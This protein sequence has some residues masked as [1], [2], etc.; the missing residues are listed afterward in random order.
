VQKRSERNSPTKRGRGG[1]KGIVRNT[2]GTREAREEK[3]AG[4]VRQ[5]NT[6]KKATTLEIRSIRS[7]V[8]T[9]R[10]VSYREHGMRKV[11]C[12]REGRVAILILSGKGRIVGTRSEKNN[13]RTAQTVV[14]QRSQVLPSRG[15]WITHILR[16]RGRGVLW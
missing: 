1:K 3:H 9:K 15:Q 16:G 4:R 11:V 13:V 7:I 2:G 12:R 14:H 5:T 10:T 6:E 8:L